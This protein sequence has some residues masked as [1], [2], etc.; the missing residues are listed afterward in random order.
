MTLTDRLTA[1]GYDVETAIADGRRRGWTAGLDET[2]DVIL[3]DVM[4]PGRDGFDVCRTLRQR[5]I[6]RRS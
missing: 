5:G 3:L 6:R 2:F 1:E 4:L